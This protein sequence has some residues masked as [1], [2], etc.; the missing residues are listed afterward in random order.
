MALSKNRVP[1]MEHHHF[2]WENPLFQWPFS[3]AMLNYQRVVQKVLPQNPSTSHSHP[4]PIPFP[5]VSRPIRATSTDPT[6]TRPTSV[7]SSLLER[8]VH[9]ALALMGNLYG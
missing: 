2:E 9:P 6:W 1:S 4:F 8:N 7:D 5:R 3:I